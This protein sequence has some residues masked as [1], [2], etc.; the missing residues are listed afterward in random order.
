MSSSPPHVKCAVAVHTAEPITELYEYIPNLH[1]PEPYSLFEP[2][3]AFTDIHPSEARLVRSLRT[4]ELAVAREN[5]FEEFQRAV[6]IKHSNLSTIYCIFAPGEI[7]TII[8]EY[9]ELSLRDLPTLVPLTEQEIAIAISQFVNVLH[10]LASSR[11]PFPCLSTRLTLNGRVK[12]LLNFGFDS[13]N[14]YDTSSCEYWEGVYGDVITDFKK[15]H[16]ECKQACGACDFFN[17]HDKE[18]PPGNHAFLETGM[19]VGPRGLVLAARQ[20]VGV[21]LAQQ[22]PTGMIKDGS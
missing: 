3:I 2:N 12:L 9:P 4:R 21:L 22:R 18:I 14:M 20:A 7:S 13:E 8:Y 19:S 11:Q 17:K 5:F 1:S 16:G 6:K 15:A 10:Y